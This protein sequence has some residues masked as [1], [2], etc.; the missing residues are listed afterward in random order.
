MTTQFKF[1]LLLV[2]FF[3]SNSSM[4]MCGFYYSVH[5]SIGSSPS[6]ACNAKYAAFAAP[7]QVMSIGLVEGRCQILVDQL[8]AD[9]SG[10]IGDGEPDGNVGGPVDRRACAFGPFSAS[11]L[12]TCAKPCPKKCPNTSGNPIDTLA[13]YKYQTETD[14]Q[15][16]L[17][18]G[19][20]F[21][22]EYFWDTER[23]LWR[24]GHHRLLTFNGNS[25][26]AERPDGLIIHFTAE[27][28]SMNEIVK[29]VDDRG[30]VEIFP[31]PG[32]HYQLQLDSVYEEYDS[33]GQIVSTIDQAG[34]VTNYIRDVAADTLTIQDP[35][36][37][38]SIV[39]F[40]HAKRI[41]RIEDSAG[42]VYRYAYDENQMLEYVSFPDATPGI[43]GSNPFIEDNPF[44]QY[45]Y[46]DINHPTALTG[47]TDERG[48]RF[49]T[50]SYNADGRAYISKYE[51][52]TATNGVDQVTLD[53][54]YV[55]DLTDPRVIETN[56]LGHVTTYHYTTIQ[57]ER[58]VTL[59]ERDVHISGQD[60][61]VTCG[62]A[63]Q[64]TSYDGYYKNLVTDCE[65]NI[66][67]YDLDAR[68]LE[69]QRIEGLRWQGDV[70]DST[71][72]STPA[73]RT[74]TTLWHPDFRLP[75]RITEPDQVID[76]T[77]DCENRRMKS[78]TVHA[79]PAPAYI[80]PSC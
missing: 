6:A 10:V 26:S 33:D 72:A 17:F 3:Y 65:G 23:G 18:K 54:T 34:R 29:W 5:G 11:V 78:R 7:E 75:T 69:T 50:W 62:A 53:Y 67:D 70:I 12:K 42:Q 9:S 19:V 77:Y 57:D 64:H 14:L 44:R 32:G 51:S 45:H 47:I 59:V 49:A 24:F 4:A 38:N 21:S 43:S 31:L 25:I 80:A 2:L 27:L 74:I 13:G 41:I 68:G 15:N 36:S 35:I 66:V 46:D 73:T 79:S 48:K 61:S 30:W 60:A 20:D 22:R 58:R 52:P 76:M 71:L 8:P 63:N 16:T 40:H 39:V 55:D 28:D 1:S 37:M 56:A